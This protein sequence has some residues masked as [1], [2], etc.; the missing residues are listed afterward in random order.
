M[1]CGRVGDLLTGETIL[2]TADSG[3]TGGGKVA[4]SALRTA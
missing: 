1:Q 2:I 4:S 3:S